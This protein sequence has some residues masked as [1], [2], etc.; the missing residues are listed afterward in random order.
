MLRSTKIGTPAPFRWL[1]LACTLLLP[2][3]PA[4]AAP[5]D[6]VWTGTSTADTPECGTDSYDVIVHIEDSWLTG[7][8][9]FAGEIGTTIYGLIDNNGSVIYGEAFEDYAPASTFTGNFAET[10]AELHWTNIENACTG[11]VDLARESSYDTGFSELWYGEAYVDDNSPWDC[12]DATF[13]VAL[14]PDGTTLRGSVVTDYD[15][16]F[17]LAGSLSGTTVSGDIYIGNPNVDGGDFSGTVSG[18]TVEGV[19]SDA[20]GCSGTFWQSRYDP[21]DSSGSGWGT[22]FLTD[23][24]WIEDPAFGTDAMR[25]D[26]IS[27][28]QNSKMSYTGTFYAGTARFSIEVSSEA[29]VGFLRFYIHGAP[30]HQ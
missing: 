16:V 2:L 8:A 4:L 21:A 15:L 20:F 6:G 5:F 17:G 18:D 28:G 12:S 13:V 24:G 11:T 27:D 29:G 3:A 9:S 23:A 7:S 19:W 14:D 10:V 26:Y 22:P 1:L 30:K 25:A